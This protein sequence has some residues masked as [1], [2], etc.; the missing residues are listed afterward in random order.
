MEVK[1]RHIS[2]VHRGVV[3]EKM[4][5]EKSTGGY[6]HRQQAIG[7]L[8]SSP[9]CTVLHLFSRVDVFRSFLAKTNLHNLYYALKVCPLN[10]DFPPHLF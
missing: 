4:T 10:L 5:R 1:V 2:D 3:L 7:K 9:K 6:L 8:L